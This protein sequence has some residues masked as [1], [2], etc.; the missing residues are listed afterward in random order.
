M[1][2]QC[3]VFT[4]HPQRILLLVN[5]CAA[6][7]ALCD[8]VTRAYG[9]VTAP[10]FSSPALLDMLRF[11]RPAAALCC[12]REEGLSAWF[13]LAR[14]AYFRCD[15][16]IRITSPPDWALSAAI[17]NCHTLLNLSHVTIQHHPIAQCDIEAMLNA[18]SMRLL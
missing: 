2:A 14:L 12:D 7:T 9:F 17:E 15:A 10:V 4:P 11:H 3:P 13:V 5:A 18:A 8:E 16:E 1:P 6:I